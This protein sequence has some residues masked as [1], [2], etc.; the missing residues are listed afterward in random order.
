MPS[1][2]FLPSPTNSRRTAPILRHERI[3]AL[4]FPRLLSSR[5]S[6][7]RCR[8]FLCR[9]AKHGCQVADVLALAVSLYPRTFY[10]ASPPLAH[11]VLRRLRPP[12]D[13]RACGQAAW[14][15]DWDR[16]RGRYGLARSRFLPNGACICATGL[17]V[18]QAFLFSVYKSSR[19]ARRFEAPCRRIPAVLPWGTL[20]GG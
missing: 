12:S 11:T 13:A 1:L 8:L 18:L 15:D 2:D 9:P 19:T 7:D 3:L 6:S 4:F 16:H 10:Q 17:L 5:P 20:P 14:I